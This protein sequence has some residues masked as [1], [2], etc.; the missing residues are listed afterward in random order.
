[1]DKKNNYI[2]LPFLNSIS[3]ENYSLFDKDWNYQIKKGLN[4]FIGANSLGKTTTT[5]LIIYGI[6]GEY[7]NEIK[8]TYFKERIP[9]VE[10]KKEKK[11]IVKLDFT[12]GTHF[13]KLYRYIE[14]DKIKY[15][16]IDKKIYQENKNKDIND[17]YKNALKKF[18]GINSIDDIVFVMNKFMIREEEGNY[19][20][21]DTA[22]QSRLIRL[23]INYSGFHE[24]Y[25]KIFEKVKE[26]DTKVRGNQDI[27]FQF[28]S[29]Q[30]D[31]KELREKELSKIKDFSSKKEIE[32]EIV[33][34]D[35]QYNRL[36]KQKKQNLENIQYLMNN[37]KSKD[38]KIEELSAEY[39]NIN[40]QII[41]LENEFFKK[42]YTDEKVLSAI[43]KLKYYGLCI[44]CNQ[45]ADDKNIK[46]IV[47]SVEFL[48]KCP[49]CDE[50]LTEDNKNDIETNES[51][52][53]LENHQSEI[54]IYKL[55]IKELEESRKNLFSELQ[56][57]T[58]N[59]KEIDNEL[60]QKAF[61]TYDLKSKLSML[62]KNP[63]EQITMYDAGINAIQD[64]IDKYN[65]TIQSA[66]TEFKKELELLNK[67]NIELNETIFSFESKLDEIFSKYANTF[68]MKNT[69]LVMKERKPKGYKIKLTT[70][71]P[72]FEDKIRTFIN[73]CSTSQRIFLE[74]LFRLSLIELYNEISNNSGFLILETSEGAFD[75]SNIIQLADLFLAFNKKGLP[76]IIIANFSKPDF[77]NRLL[78]DIQ[79]P[80]NIVLNYLDFGNLTEQQKKDLP[81][82]NKILKDLKLT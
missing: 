56:E 52:K 39:D 1:M 47:K 31:L 8:A 17:V 28:L 4:L 69:N 18:T 42:I 29:R 30:K 38:S 76:F 11:A 12:I 32:S 19:L 24:E 13:L 73:Y 77:L 50:H 27:R 62:N 67:K 25:L 55:Q 22:D 3:V 14:F 26:W 35:N 23:L 64:E 58:N 2:K 6:V 15:L 61:Q 63:E 48:H 5:N 37:L 53:S 79:Y 7:E 40:E 65:V 34:I 44:F 43:H 71:V 41:T 59:Q 20:L 33:K 68:F 45:K 21:W 51:I 81:K 60:N 74:Y 36:K 54:D 80:E 9:F 78:K 49:L 82:F 46:N 72:K 70:Y 75:M 66:Q 16:E 10:E 57:K